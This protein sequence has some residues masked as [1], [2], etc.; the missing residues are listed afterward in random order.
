MRCISLQSGSNGNSIYVEADGVRLLNDAGISG[1]QAQI[2]LMDHGIDIR[3]VDALILSHDH[4]DHTS[5]AGIYHRKF[6]LPIYATPGTWRV[7]RSSAGPV[8]DIRLF[9]P[10]GALKFGHARIQAIPTPHDGAEGVAFVIESDSR[11]LGILTDLGNPFP[12]LKQ[13]FSTLDAALLESNYDVDMLRNGP[14]PRVLQDRI[15]GPHGH[16]SNVE[17]AQLVADHGKRLRWLAIGHLSEENNAPL[18]AMKTHRSHHEGLCPIHHA[19][20]YGVSEVWEL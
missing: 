7:C 5:C 15:R 6:G 3:E 16:L 8:R 9:Q 14:Y 4:R 20:R 10:G 13:L 2:R 12:E 17:S 1:K 18:I 11:R 19:S